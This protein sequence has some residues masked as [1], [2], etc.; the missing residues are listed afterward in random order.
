MFL[1]PARVLFFLGK[2]SIL[3][4]SLLWSI[5]QPTWGEKKRIFTVIAFLLW[6]WNLLA[7]YFWRAGHCACEGKNRML[8][9]PAQAHSK[10]VSCL[11]HHQYSI[12][13]NI[14]W[15]KA[16]MHSSVYVTIGLVC[17]ITMKKN[18]CWIKRIKKKAWKSLHN[19]LA[20]V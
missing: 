11:H 10:H 17:I 5:F 2:I 3:I 4:T 16:M 14:S 7:S 18:S 6:C 13:G 1:I 12:E 9:M 15:I 8:W 20:C 19:E